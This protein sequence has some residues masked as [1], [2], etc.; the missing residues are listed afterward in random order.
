MNTTKI[1]QKYYNRNDLAYSILV[2]H[3]KQVAQKALYLAENNPG[4]NLDLVFIEEAAMLHDIGIFMTNAPRIGCFGAYPYLCHG[5][6]GAELLRKEGFLKHALVCERHTGVGLSVETIR[7]EKLPLPE[8]E[9][10]PVSIEEQLICFADKFFSKNHPE[11]EKS[12]EHIRH[13]IIKYGKGA[14]LRFE[15]WCNMFLVS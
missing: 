10:I 4:L 6:L 3:S 5:Y 11:F 9:M 1:I 14:S 7:K 12:L 2:A 8:K 15:E 13:E